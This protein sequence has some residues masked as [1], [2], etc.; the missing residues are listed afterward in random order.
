MK[1]SV[2]TPI[3][4]LTAGK[5]SLT[6]AWDKVAGAD[7]YDIFFA[8]CNHNKKKIVCSNVK[9]IEGNNTFAWTNSGLRPGTS[10][11]AYVK[12][13]V[14]KDGKKTYIKKTPTMHAF[15]GNGN[16]KYT[17]AKSVTL[18]KTNITL[19]LNDKKSYKIKAT[20]N[21][22]KKG[23]KLM[24]E[25]H[26]PKLRYMTSDG[27]VATVNAKGKITAKGKGTCYIT[28]YAHNGV[29]KKVKVTVN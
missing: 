12:A 5:R 8:R 15:T 19:N 29:S 16:K 14:L 24:S 25:N 23:R 3:A 6:I 26:T 10:Y 20:V 11:K 28:V 7:G 17:N 21:K 2:A 9:S 27:A 1:T 22:F 4:K 13:Y 18:K